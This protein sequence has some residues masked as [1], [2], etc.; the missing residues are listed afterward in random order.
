[1]SSRTG[2]Q[3]ERPIAENVDVSRTRE[4]AESIEY[5]LFALVDIAIIAL[6]PAVNDPNSA[7]EVIE[8][9]SFLFAE[10]AKDPLGPYVVPDTDSWPCVVV[11]AR[12]FGELVE[13]ATTQ[14]VL[15]GIND[16]LVVFTLR[17][18]ANSLQ[19]IDLSD[20]DRAHVDA[21][22]AKLDDAASL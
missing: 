2:A 9:M 18:F 4:L 17:R 7:V 19:M 15:Y 10:I 1:M 11:K 14:I 16:P 8:E 6:S 22:A 5:G 13:L 12:T 21:F 3:P 20:A